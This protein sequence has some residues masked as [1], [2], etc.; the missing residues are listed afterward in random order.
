MDFNHLVNTFGLY[1]TSII[2]GFSS[3]L[4]P[5]IN[6]EAYLLLLGFL[7]KDSRLYFLLFLLTLAHLSGKVV[8][9]LIGRGS[10]KLNLF[11]LENRIERAKAK[12][13]MVRIGSLWTLLVSALVGL[14]PFYVV[15][16]LAGTMKIKLWQFFSIGFAGRLIRFSILLFLPQLVAGILK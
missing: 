2:V 5:V 7:L 9:Y 13:K 3:A 14:P 4:I 15:T 8:L 11:D 1:L 6:I 16:I 10:L 12:Y